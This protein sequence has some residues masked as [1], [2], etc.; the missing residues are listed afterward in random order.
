MGGRKKALF[1]VLFLLSA[2]VITWP[3]VTRLAGALY[4][5]PGDPV[6]VAWSLRWLK[7][8]L[9]GGRGDFLHYG[10]AGFPVGI[11]GYLPL[12][13]LFSP[14]ALLSFL[15]RGEV[16]LYNLIILVSLA[17]NGYVMFLLG[18]RLFANLPAALGMGLIYQFC[19]YA[20]TRARYHH[21]LVE[22]FVF[23]L[24]LYALLRFREGR[25]GKGKALFF[26]ALLVSLNVHPYYAC[27]SVL[28]LALLFLFYLARKAARGKERLAEALRP[29]RELLPTFLAAVCITV[30]LNSVYLFLFGN[31][32]RSVV[33]REG[34]LYTYA[35]HAWNYLVPSAR[36]NL[37]GGGVGSF[38]SGKVLPNNVEEYVLFLGY[39]NMGLAAVALATWLTGRLKG[40]GGLS[41]RVKAAR[42]TWVVP[43]SLLLAAACVVFSLQP[44]IE[45]AGITLYMPSWFIYRVFP[46]VRV[47]S[48]FG[49]L[50]FLAVTLMSGACLALVAEAAAK[51]WRPLS[52]LAVAFLTVLALAEFA[53]LGRAPLQELYRY[54]RVYEAVRDLPENAVIA[55]YPFVASDES[56]NSL[57][58]WNQ[59]YH[60]RRMLNGYR[61]ETRE[62]VLRMMA[63][64]LLD[65]R[66]PTL[67]AYLGADAVVVH[68]DLYRKGSE[69]SYGSSQIDLRD[70]PGGLSVL[71]EDGESAILEVD[72]ERPDFVVRYDEKCSLAVVPGM[73]VG[74]WL[75]FGRNWSMTVD[76]ARDATVDIEFQIYS[77]AWGRELCVDLGGGRVERVGVPADA[78]VKVRLGGVGLRRGDNEIRLWTDSQE[79]PFNAVFGGLDL[80]PVSFAMTFWNIGD[81]AV[82]QRRDLGP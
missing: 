74:F 18:T 59:L 68:K 28:L 35:A 25:D 69:Y 77:P 1:F 15:P 45:L 66:T 79:V 40:D 8:S 13:L 78:P 61:L 23:P 24:L 39:A 33:R 22:I 3:L 29:V 75:Q 72:A 12:P 31:G 63:L 27:A 9:L 53:E 49:V 36:S 81:A 64:N 55:E 44:K 82:S 32:I 71:Y 57:Y 20:L 21:T 14:L 38:L 58:L 6:N 2:C 7:D 70:L 42:G 46:L 65:A 52:S 47:Y 54:E 56:I 80:K 30:V 41:R 43:F 76:A 4:G 19:P 26:A 17:L 60:G 34:D 16:V 50:V 73:D 11:K 10:Y 51:R 5:E 67:L 48:R 37:L 62:E